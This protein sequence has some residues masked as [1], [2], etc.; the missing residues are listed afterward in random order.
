MWNK[1]PHDAVIVGFVFAHDDYS[2]PSKGN[3][4]TR[5]YLNAEEGWRGMVSVPDHRS[6]SITDS[7]QIFV[8]KDA[9][10]LYKI[11]KIDERY[12]KNDLFSTLEM[13]PLFAGERMAAQHVQE[14][15]WT[16]R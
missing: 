1:P 9:C 7:P 2:K 15:G 4:F 8:A 13:I 10:R 6:L 14:V 16:V 5:W 11:I 12:R 3:P